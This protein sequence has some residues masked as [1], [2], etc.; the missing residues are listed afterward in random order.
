MMNFVGKIFKR[1]LRSLF[2]MYG[3]ALLT[4]LFAVVLVQFFP[5]GPVWPVPIFLVFMLVI[6]GRY[7]KW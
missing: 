7:V 3:P 2:S 1:L 6:F 5:D 4:L